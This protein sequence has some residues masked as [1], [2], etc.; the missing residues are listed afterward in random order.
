MHGNPN[1]KNTLPHSQEPP[2]VPI[3]RQM[4][5]VHALSAYFIKRH[6]ILSSHLCPGLPVISFLQVFPPKG[7]WYENLKDFFNPPYEPHAM[8]NLSSLI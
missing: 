4:N 2:L 6:L 5:T 3:L 8:P 1:I 7:S